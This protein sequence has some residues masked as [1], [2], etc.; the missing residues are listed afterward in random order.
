MLF[1]SQ[2]LIKLPKATDVNLSRA[3]LAGE[4]AA[5]P[6]VFT[7]VT[8]R[9]Y[10]DATGKVMRIFAISKKDLG[11]SRQLISYLRTLKGE[12][13]EGTEIYV[14][15]APAQ[16]F[17]LINKIKSTFPWIAFFALLVSLGLMRRFLSSLLIPVKAII[18][19]LLSIASAV[20]TV[21]FFMAHGLGVYQLSQI[22][23][24]TLLFI[25]AI[26]FEIGRAHV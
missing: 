22:E 21:V 20:G 6:D 18:L 2:I 26:L 1:R 17:D 19:D 23:I 14:G 15:G 3:K 10:V 24:W 9:K 5:H 11:Q 4:I 25:F 13:P 7:V 12:F 16:G 8:D